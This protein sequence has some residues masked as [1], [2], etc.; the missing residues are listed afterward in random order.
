MLHTFLIFLGGG[1]GAVCRHLVG[2]ATLRQ[3]G[4]GFPVGTMTVNV[5]GSL[6]MGLVIGYLAKRGGNSEIRL[7][8]TT[9]FLGGFTTFSAFSLDFAN[10][11]SRGENFMA[12]GYAFSSVILSLG[13]VFIGMYLMRG[14]AV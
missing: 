11:W 9:G 10:L 6:L 2:M 13:A 4:A 1:A 8:L 12:I 7:L 3:F 14:S 5:V